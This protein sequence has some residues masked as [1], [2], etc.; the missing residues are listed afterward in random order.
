MS[1]AHKHGM[2]SVLT[3]KKKT[4]TLHTWEAHSPLKRSFKRKE[5]FHCVTHSDRQV[6]GNGTYLFISGLMK[7]GFDFI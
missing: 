1:A 4:Q 6:E 7:K 5:K 3:V 2:I